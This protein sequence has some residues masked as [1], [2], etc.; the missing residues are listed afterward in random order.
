MTIAMRL[1]AIL[2]V[3][4]LGSLAGCTRAV[5]YNVEGHPIPLRAQELSSE[6][7]EQVIIATGF[8][9]GWRI[10]AISRT[11]LRGTLQDHGHVA[12]IGISHTRTSYSIRLISSQNLE[13]ENGRIH[14]N[15]NKWIHILESDIDAALYKATLR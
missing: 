5:V 12:N 2:G 9:R 4:L 6:Q 14:R 11:E 3:L 8:K 13:Q 15:Y 1:I 10:D 7:I